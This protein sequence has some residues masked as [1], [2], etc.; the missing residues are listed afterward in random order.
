VNEYGI[1]GVYVSF[2]GGKDSTVL[3]TIS[4]EMYPDVKA[5]FVDTGLEYPEIRDFVRTWINVEWI[6]PKM[7]F[8]QVIEKYGYPFISKQV[9]KRL[10]EWRNTIQKGKDI[11][12]TCAYKEFHGT[13][14]Y[15][16]GDGAEPLKSLFSK[17][18][19]LFMAQSRYKFSHKC[20]DVMKKDSFKILGNKYPMTGQM[21][22]ESLNR[23]KAWLQHGCNAFDARTP[24]SNPMAFWTEQDVLQYIKINDVKIAS[25]YGDVVEDGSGKLKTTGCQR[26]GCMFCGF[27]CHREKPGEGRFELMKQT[28]PKQYQWIMKSW[29]EGGLG[30][31]EVI[32]WLNEHG[33]LNIRY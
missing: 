17:E 25:V 13:S 24:I 2:S 23:K 19:W 30:Y 29:E 26:T 8:R 22:Q 31:K 10:Q 16:K 33:G 3:L 15:I 27:G 9:S 7:T 11:T 28:H 20:C 14:Y 4:R 18:K 12:K 6:R 21:A 1:D 32:D 5:V